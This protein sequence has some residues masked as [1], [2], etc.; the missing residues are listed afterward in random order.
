MLRDHHQRRTAMGRNITIGL[1]TLIIILIL[2]AL[3]F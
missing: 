2:V 1:G 3:L